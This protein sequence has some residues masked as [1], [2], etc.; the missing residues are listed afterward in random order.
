MTTWPAPSGPGDDGGSLAAIP[1]LLQVGRYSGIQLRGPG[2]LL[3]QR[4]GEPLHLLLERL[5]VVLGSLGANIAA[6]REH[7]AVLADVLQFGAL[8]EAGH[9]GVLA[10]I[11]VAAPGVV[12]AGDLRDVGIKQLAVH[13]VG[14]GAELA[15][16]DEERLAAPVA[17][18]A[19][20]LVAGEE[21]E[22]HRNRRRVEELA[23]Q[24][25]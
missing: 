24:R 25:H 14:H 18:A 15:R 23:R 1:K 11:L 3:A 6:G 8:A 19:V 20:P 9:V 2:L 22:A 4:R 12:G 7:V 13:A 21:P 16:V 10:R 17:E 5:A